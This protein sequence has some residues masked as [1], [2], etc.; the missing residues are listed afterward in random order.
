MLGTGTE[1]V[2]DTL[3]RLFP[4]ARIAR[5]DRDTASGSG[6]SS[7]LAQMREREIDILVGTQMV[8]KGHDFP[9]VTLVCVL[10]ADA[11]LKLPDF[12]SAER[13]VQ[14]LAQ[15]AGRAGRAERPG[16]V[17][18]QSY[19]PTHHALTAIKTHDHEGF[20]N[21][22]ASHREL[23]GYPPYTHAIALRVEGQKQRDVQ[24]FMKRIAQVIGELLA[25]STPGRIRG[26]APAIVE[27]IRGKCR[28]AC[29]VTHSDR[30][31]LHVAVQTARQR[32]E[33]PKGLRLIVDVDPVDLM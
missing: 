33:I 27:R 8:T 5:L 24:Q 14:L 21:R 31:T 10:D 11:G 4:N 13:T 18:I 1:K 12:R 23:F 25:T 20:V 22:E 16:R 17:L 26:P 7:I 30:N 2:E 15:V 29:L 32:L 3:I 28:W 19:T 6:L 9:F